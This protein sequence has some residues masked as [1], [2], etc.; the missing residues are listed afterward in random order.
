MQYHRHRSTQSR[1]SA[2]LRRGR[3]ACQTHK[4]FVEGGEAPPTTE[5]SVHDHND[6]CLRYTMPRRGT[7]AVFL[8]RK[9][10]AALPLR[11]HFRIVPAYAL[12]HTVWYQSRW[13]CVAHPAS[14]VVV[15]SGRPFFGCSQLPNSGSDARRPPVV[16]LQT[17]SSSMVCWR[18]T[19]KS[20]V[21]SC[22]GVMTPGVCCSTFWCSLSL[23]Q[24]PMYKP[25]TTKL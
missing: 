9:S 1:I 20:L 24:S 2:A 18:R 8:L 22:Q 13:R 15:D 11:A 17:A 25:M 12:S 23:S 3:G 14:T 21:G 4:A 19:G 6:D 16:T 7:L 10:A 5:L